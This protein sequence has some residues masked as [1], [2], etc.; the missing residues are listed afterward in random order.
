MKLIEILHEALIGKEVYLYKCNFKG[1]YD[2]SR[3]L[4]HKLEVDPEID[5]EITVE[6]I[7]GTVLSVS[8]EFDEV[9]GDSI[10]ILIKVN[11]KLISVEVYTIDVDI[12]FKI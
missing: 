7:H 5:P 8:N 1:R 11:E 6:K 9:E 3:H 12:E 2:Y 10:D 4:L